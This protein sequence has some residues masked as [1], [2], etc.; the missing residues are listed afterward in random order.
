MKRSGAS[1]SGYHFLESFE[2]CKRKWYIRYI[3]GIE[4]DRK[5]FQLIFGG[6]F[7]HGKAIFYETKSE[8]KAIAAYLQALKESKG[9]VE[10]ASTL[11]PMMVKRGPIMLSRWINLLGRNDLQTYKILALEKVIKFSLPNGYVFTMKPDVVMEADAG[12]YLFDTKTSWYSANLQAEQVETGDQS[13]AYLYGWNLT[14]PKKKAIGLVPDCI[15]WNRNTE[16]PDKINCTRSKL[17]S[18]TERELQEWVEGTM[19]NLADMASRV[20]GLVKHGDAATFPRTT[21]YCLSYNR[22]CEY[23]DICRHRI[24]GIPPGFHKN[25]WKGQ[26]ALLKGTKK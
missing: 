17:V 22:A 21:S 6:C 15:Y 1:K 10:D 20:R 9:E 19:S 11:Y 2:T 16:D 5:P 26:E 3:L 23:L 25:T 12:I 18:R 13:T 4:P 7:H 8:K 14:H 24:E